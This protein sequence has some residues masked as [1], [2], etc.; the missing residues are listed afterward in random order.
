MTLF[1]LL[2]NWLETASGS[3]SPRQG[4]VSE[5]GI[6][7]GPSSQRPS[8]VS[9]HGVLQLLTPPYPASTFELVQR[10]SQPTLPR[11]LVEPPNDS[12]HQLQALK[13]APAPTF[14]PYRADGG[15]RPHGARRP[16]GLSAAC[17]G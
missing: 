13:L 12:A 14:V 3:R 4:R 11:M 9:F 7:C 6:S 2:V 1:D 10:A 8:Q 16:F 17:A 5:M 15:C